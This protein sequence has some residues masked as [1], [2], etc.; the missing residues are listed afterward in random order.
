MSG[1]VHREWKRLQWYVYENTLFQ[2]LTSYISVVIYTRMH[3]YLVQSTLLK[4]LK[5]HHGK[6][7]TYSWFKGPLKHNLH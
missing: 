4:L 3:I 1:G 7:D 5:G 6:T 2:N